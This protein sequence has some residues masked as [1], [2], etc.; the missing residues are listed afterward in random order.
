[1]RSV[2]IAVDGAARGNNRADSSSRAAWGVYW[3]LNCLSNRCGLVPSDEPQRSNRAELEAVHQAILS[4]QVRRDEGELDGWREIIIKLD[5]D[6]VKKT[7]DEYIWNYE[8]N[9]WRKSDGGAIKHL[10][11]IQDIR[12]MICEMERYGAVRFWRVDRK[13]NEDADELAN[14]ALDRGSNSGFRGD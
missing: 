5:S 12:A 3:G 7:F 8:K 13:W 4:V 11:L 10:A 14:M 1:M 9:G 2:V 6:Y